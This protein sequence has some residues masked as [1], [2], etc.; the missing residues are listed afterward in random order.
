MF[1]M[2][3]SETPAD[4]VG[5]YRALL[6]RLPE[7]D[8]DAFALYCA[9]HEDYRAAL[10]DKVHNLSIAER[11]PP[12]DA[13]AWI[14]EF[15]ALAAAIEAIPVTRAPQHAPFV[16][17]RFHKGDKKPAEAP[18]LVAPV[19]P[20]TKKIITLSMVRRG[21]A[22][23]LPSFADDP[24]LKDVCIANDLC[25]RC[26]ESKFSAGHSTVA[27]PERPGKTKLICSNFGAGDEQK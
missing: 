16:K 20:S 19:A 27:D 3:K 23:K 7:S 15:D 21:E 10:I 8:A 1:Q 2:L 17:P 6:Q 24:E 25:F 4:F 14:P 5:R 11:I 26:R 12:H 9:V 22:A 18:A 13:G